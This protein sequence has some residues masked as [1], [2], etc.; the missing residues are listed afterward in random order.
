MAAE[1]VPATSS[2][3]SV[4]S[5]VADASGEGSGRW[6]AGTPATICLEYRVAWGS[7]LDGRLDVAY[8]AQTGP[9]TPGLVTPA[10]H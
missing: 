2:A 6:A 7:N 9:A 1:L 5:L 3:R 4:G 8:R 10:A